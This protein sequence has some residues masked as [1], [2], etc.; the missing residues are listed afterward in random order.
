M[1]K[2]YE[3]ILWIFKDLEELDFDDLENYQLPQLL[4]PSCNS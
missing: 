2:R 4:N 1:F 3:K